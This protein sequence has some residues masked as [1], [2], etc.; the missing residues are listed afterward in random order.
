M[1][2]DIVLNYTVIRVSRMDELVGKGFVWTNKLRALKLCKIRYLLNC[3]SLR[4][5]IDKLI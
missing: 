4:F 2:I 5:A 1:R 3:R